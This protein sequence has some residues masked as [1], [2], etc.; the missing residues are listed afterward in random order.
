MFG[1]HGL[2]GGEELPARG[3][4]ASQC[5]FSSSFYLFFQ[6]LGM[7]SVWMWGDFLTVL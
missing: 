1:G 6:K 5:T 3:K 2:R 7:I 4:R